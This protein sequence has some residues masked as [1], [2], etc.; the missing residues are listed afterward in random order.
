MKVLFLTS[1]YPNYNMPYSHMFVHMR[2]KEFKRQNFCVEVIVPSRKDDFYIYDNIKVIKNQV[3]KILSKLCNYDIIYIHLLN[4]Y[5]FS[6]INNWLIYKEILKR[7]YKFAI[8]IHGSE[9]LSFKERYFGNYLNI[10]DLLMWI[11]KDLYQLPKIKKFLKNFNYS[12]GIVITPSN[13]MKIKICNILKKEKKITVIP[14]GIDTKMFKFK[15]NSNNSRI[16]SIRP[17]GDKVYD[18]ESTIKIMKFLPDNYTLDIY[19]EGRYSN[20]YNKLIIAQGLSS[21]VKIINSFIERN[22]MNTLFHNYCIFLTTTK[23]DTQGVT[24]LEAM[25]SGLLV[26]SINNSSKKEF[27]VDFKT[28]VLADNIND[29]SK[30]ILKAF[31]SNLY[32]EVIS[33]ARKSVEKINIEKT[34]KLET[35]ILRDL[36]NKNKL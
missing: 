35:R 22:V 4:L 27:I 19:G 23:L 9:F 31:N 18:I 25:S 28:G 32:K 20:Y 13:W 21:R 7:K 15:P 36:F 10:R 6:K 17:L 2:V 30:K 8:Y 12:N 11:R 3:P 26:A 33:S 29:L 24:M 5:P 16:L 14:N 34:C 1:R